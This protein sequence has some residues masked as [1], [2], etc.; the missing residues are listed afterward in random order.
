MT[1][2]R[3]LYLFLAALTLLR[4][5]FCTL[6]D[7]SPDEAYY[8]L[9]SQKLDICYYSKGPGVAVAMWLG[10]HLRDRPSSA[11]ASFHLSFLWEPSLLMFSFARR[12]YSES[13]AIWTVI[14]FSV[15]PI[16]S[17]GSMVMTIDP[18]S[19]FFWMAAL[20]AFW[21]ALERDSHSVTWWVATG[22]LIGAGFLCKYTNAMQLLSILLLLLLT[23]KHR[24]Q[25]AR[26][27][28]WL[29]L[30]VF[31]LSAIPPILWN[32]SH[33][34]ITLT[35]LTARG[36]LH[37]LGR[38]HPDQFLKY[39]VLHLGVYSPLIFIAMTAAFFWAI[40]RGRTHFK[41]RFLITFAAPIYIMYFWLAFGE[42]GEPNWT[43]PGSISL[44]LLTVALFHEA[45]ER[46][47]FARRF[48]MAALAIALTMSAVILDTDVVRKIGIRWP[49][50][51]DPSSRV[52]GWESFAAKVE[53]ARKSFE[54]TSGQPAF[55]IAN[56]YQTASELAFYLKDK[57][58]AAPGHP[59]AYI[60]ES[61][62]IQNEFSFWPRY[63]ETV[64]LEVL[65]QG[66]LAAPAEPK[67]DPQ[68][69]KEVETALY[70]LQEKEAHD[71]QGEE[72]GNAK[73]ALAHALH[74]AAPDLPI[75]ESY[76]EEQGPN[77]FFGR[78]ALY[79]TDRPEDRPPTT[80]QGGF[81]KSEMI[82]CI[83]LE[84]SGNV[85]RQLRI[86]ACYNYHGMSL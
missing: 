37:K 17:V 62:D 63:D 79:I 25:F 34:W 72:L 84:R 78:N 48:S 19:M 32:R 76:V 51:S 85:L 49:Y 23:P 57:R 80:I 50:D 46:S 8:Y 86:F 41:P 77:L 7:L 45:S 64:T 6:S 5:I 54:A 11:F 55:L 39:F 28:F 9:W 16:F 43:A 66:C 61:Q 71:V 60:T 15:I 26:P 22:A 74:L 68:I 3:L 30:L 20:Y 29:M 83:D 65:A 35:H 27:G 38:F 36:G 67:A 24:Q 12:L 40:R 2:R 42:A 59:P 21:L 56:R 14:A 33:D 13:I 69:R 75:D 47:V 81:E 58:P 18:L 52:R 82:A 31:A 4:L 10:T 73:R 70:A 1:P 53:S 44:G